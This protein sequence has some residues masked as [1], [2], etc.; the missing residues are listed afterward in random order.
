MKN[1]VILINGLGL[2]NSTRCKVLID[3]LI[4]KNFEIT[5]LTSGNGKD[6]FKY[7]NYK[8]IPLKQIDY[9]KKNGKLSIFKL[10]LNLINIIKIV[11]INSTN[12]NNV[13]K[14]VNADLIISDSIY[15]FPGKDFKKRNS[16]ALNNS[17]LIIRYFFR[18]KKKPL[19]IYPQFFLI[20][21]FDY[22]ISKFVYKKIWSPVISINDL[23]KN[24]KNNK[25]IFFLPPISRFK[26]NFIKVESSEIKNICVMLSGSSF[27]TKVFFSK[28][29]LDKYN[30]YLINYKYKLGSK[31]Y[32]NH[33]YFYKEFDNF[34]ILKKCDIAIINSGYSAIA[35]CINLEIPM[36]L[37]PINNHAEQYIN[38]S[39]VKNEN[40]GI[41]TSGNLNEDIKIM[42]KSYNLF[43]KNLKINKKII[44]SIDYFDNDLLK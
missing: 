2:G 4:S 13:I 7:N 18:F 20:E 6:Y 38:S 28:I 30:F 11:Q 14:K 33:K 39:I 37:M 15:F 22:L 44:N 19:N 8:I 36:I 23:K 40:F 16:V 17:N 41:L 1:A 25:K 34:K 9:D 27:K 24:N 5:I 32:T 42:L 12:I 43:K 3:W 21:L 35:D 31:D 10:I 29:N 26:N